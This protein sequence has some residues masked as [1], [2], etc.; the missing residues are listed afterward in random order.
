MLQ[1]DCTVIVSNLRASLLCFALQIE[2][3][4]LLEAHMA[5]LRQ[6]YEDWADQEPEELAD[7]PSEEEVATFEEGEK[8]HRDKVRCDSTL[9]T[10]CAC[11][12]NRLRMCATSHLFYVPFLSS[13]ER[14]STRLLGFRRHLELAN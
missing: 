10:L 4:R 7:R 13:L 1:A 8:A 11:C 12:A 6:D 14:W 5:C 3:V 9:E 2:P